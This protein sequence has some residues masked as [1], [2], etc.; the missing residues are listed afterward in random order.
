MPN[1]AN[2]NRQWKLVFVDDDPGIINLYNKGIERFTKRREL[3]IDTTICTDTN[4]A[5]AVATSTPFETPILWIVDSMM[6]PTQDRKAPYEDE[7]TLYT[8]VHLIEHLRSVANGKSYHYVILTNLRPNDVQRKIAD[9]PVEVL[10]KSQFSPRR[11]AE[12]VDAILAI[13]NK[14]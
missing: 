8:G 7:D 6:Q 11:F 4:E 12:R 13:L 2:A 10:E 9:A 5:I 14:K 1:A 3:I